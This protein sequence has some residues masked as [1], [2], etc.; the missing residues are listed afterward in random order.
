[1]IAQ[2]YGIVVFAENLHL[3]EVKAKRVNIGH[4]K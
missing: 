2:K 4:N 3:S 1:M